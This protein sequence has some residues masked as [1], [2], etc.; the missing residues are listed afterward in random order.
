MTATVRAH[1]T[2]PAPARLAEVRELLDKA[3]RATERLAAGPTRRGAATQDPPTLPVTPALAGLFVGGGMR[4]GTTLALGTSTALLLALLSEASTRGSWCAVVGQ[5]DLGLV[6]AHESG[7]ALERLA[8]V[9]DPADQLVAVTS[10]LLEGA[11]IVAIAGP[12]RVA[13]GD[14]QRLAAKARQS[15]A[16]L[17]ASGIPWPGADLELELRLHP[18][19]WDGLCG[20]GRGRLRARR[21]EVRAIGRAGAH[22]PRTATVLLPGSDGRACAA[23]GSLSSANP[24][25]QVAP[26]VRKQAG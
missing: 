14:R 1:S 23:A 13:A 19:Q 24:G 18:G 3:T 2:A 9:P 8:L 25:A 17:I 21:A 7:I 6:A 16:V 20:Q 22:R 5:P 10:A 4:K 26:A 12:G 15:G 11:E